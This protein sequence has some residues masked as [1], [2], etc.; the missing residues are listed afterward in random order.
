M[1]IGHATRQ[2]ALHST[3][4]EAREDLKSGTNFLNPR[5]EENGA[6]DHLLI[7]PDTG[8]EIDVLMP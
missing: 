6:D 1:P 3:P 5:S 4:V 7:F 8:G 2:G